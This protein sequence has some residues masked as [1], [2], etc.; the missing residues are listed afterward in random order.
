MTRRKRG[1][2]AL[3]HGGGLARA[4]RIPVFTRETV[5]KYLHAF[6]TRF[7]EGTVHVVEANGAPA[8]WTHIDGHEQLTAFDVRDGRVHG[9][10]AVLNPDKLGRVRPAT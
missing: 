3:R 2:H 4:S 7:W 1:K 5:A 8:L 6:H 10:F 9:L